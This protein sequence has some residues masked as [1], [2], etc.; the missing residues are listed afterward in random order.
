MS[1]SIFGYLKKFPSQG[2]EMNPQSL[3]VNVEYE[4]FHMNDDFWNQYAYFSGDIDE[5]F[6]APLIDELNIH[7]FMD[8]NHIH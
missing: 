5:Q 3:T 7:L 6:P 8:L 4:K 1:R 2:Y